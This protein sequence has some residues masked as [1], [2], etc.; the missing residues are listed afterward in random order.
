ML[1]ASAT[2][3]L[4]QQKL[5]LNSTS[6][7]KR[8]RSQT[9]LTRAALSKTWTSRRAKRPKPVEQPSNDPVQVLL[10]AKMDEMQQR[11]ECPNPKQEPFLFRL[12]SPFFVVVH[13][14][15]RPSP[16]ITFRGYTFIPTPLLAI[17]VLWVAVFVY[18]YL[19]F[20]A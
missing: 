14:T 1:R 2:C 6:L 3:P 16:F 12:I 7:S 19:W 18:L 8:V 20:S 5:C 11:L 17:L 4:H 10:L 9:V 15:V 13:H